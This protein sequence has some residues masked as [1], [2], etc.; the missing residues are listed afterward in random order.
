[1]LTDEARLQAALELREVA[2]QR[3]RWKLAFR[4]SSM[5]PTLREGDLLS[6]V[7]ASA[8]ELGGGEIV[9]FRRRDQYVVHRFLGRSPFDGRLLTKGDNCLRRD[10]PIEAEALVGRVVGV[11]RGGQRLELG[12]P[13][14]RAR[15]ALASLLSLSVSAT[16]EVARAARR[17]IDPGLRLRL[18]LPLRQ[19]L[20][21]W[22]LAS[23][24]LLLR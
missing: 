18:P 5:L 2:G 4:G 19:R 20:R 22:A 21:E 3:G 16:L 9:V 23:Q 11:D 17:R 13:A 6:V 14:G 1:M 8:G 10:Q 7:R 24:R 12:P 15:S